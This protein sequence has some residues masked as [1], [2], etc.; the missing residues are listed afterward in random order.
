MSLAELDIG[1]EGRIV[2][3]H[4]EQSMKHRLNGFGIIKGSEIKTINKGIGI[5]IYEIKGAHIELRNEDAAKILID[6]YSKKEKN[7]Q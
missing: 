6:Y 2:N 4:A 7:K 3:I 1:K 5:K